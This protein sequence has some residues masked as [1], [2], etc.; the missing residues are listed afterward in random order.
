MYSGRTVWRRVEDDGY[1]QEG[2]KQ[3]RVASRSLILPDSIFNFTFEFQYIVLALNY[4]ENFAISLHKTKSFVRVRPFVPNS[5]IQYRKCHIIE[6][7]IYVYILHFQ[8]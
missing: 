7:Y 4:R 8:I 5:L 1:G 6:S 2:M 3:T